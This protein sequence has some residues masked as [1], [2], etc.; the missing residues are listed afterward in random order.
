MRVS[1]A[2]A[3]ANR[4]RIVDTASRLFREHGIDATGVAELMAEA[5]LTHGGFYGHF[6]SKDDLATEACQRAGDEATA[7]WTT[8]ATRDPS[9]ALQTLVESYLTT[10]HR[11]GRNTGCFMPGLSADVAR[12]QNP[13]LRG[14]FTNGVRGCLD[15]L[16]DAVHGR[17]RRERRRRALATLSAMVGAMVLARAVDDAALSDEVLKAT[18]LELL[19]AR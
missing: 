3:E 2:Q 17:T 1:K 4:E 18:Q 6:A 14:A 13:S 12:T 8:R 15:V 9:R 11:D 16:A 7:K 5:G 19:S 10:A